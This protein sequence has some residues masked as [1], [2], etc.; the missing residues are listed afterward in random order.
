MS[1]EAACVGFMF[2]LHECKVCLCLCACGHLTCFAAVDCEVVFLPDQSL[3]QP[4]SAT[5]HLAGVGR[6]FRRGGGR[7]G[8]VGAANFGG[9]GDRFDQDRGGLVE[10][11]S[12]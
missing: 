4:R 5:N 11:V 3:G 1:V 8:A 7:G 6:Q 2:L 10:A 12:T 9:L